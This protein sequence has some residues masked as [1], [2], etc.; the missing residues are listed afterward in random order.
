MN[1]IKWNEWSIKEMDET[2]EMKMNEAKWHEW[3]KKNE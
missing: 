2:N 1:K 3:I